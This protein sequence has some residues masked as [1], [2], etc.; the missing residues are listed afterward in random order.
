MS[1]HLLANGAD[2]VAV[3]RGALAN[4]DFP[5]VLQSKREPKDFDGTVLQ[6]IA[7]IKEEELAMQTAV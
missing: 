7:N 5:K 6:P 1:E 2:I 3:G 4:P